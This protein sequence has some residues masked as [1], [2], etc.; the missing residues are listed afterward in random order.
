MEEL[1]A[2]RQEIATRANAAQSREA[3]SAGRSATLLAIVACG[4]VAG[5]IGWNLSV[6]RRERES[7]E[8]PLFQFF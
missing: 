8:D 5:V 3:A 1:Q 7:E 4:A 6:R 2:L